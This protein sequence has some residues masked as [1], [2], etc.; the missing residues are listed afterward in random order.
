MVTGKIPG[1]YLHLSR[2]G[3][4]SD[5]RP[6]FR[7]FPTYVD[8]IPHVLTEAHGVETLSDRQSSSPQRI[9]FPAPKL[10]SP[11]SLRARGIGCK[12]FCTIPD[13]IRRRKKTNK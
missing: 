7:Q 11:S 1:F 8:V 10:T 2:P 12:Q 9:Q 6:A 5:E 13:K 3:V 4:L